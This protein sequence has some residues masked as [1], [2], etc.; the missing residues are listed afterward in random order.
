MS[1]YI[2]LNIRVNIMNTHVK[3]RKVGGSLM[4]SLPRDVVDALG[5][6]PGQTLPVSVEDGRLV[7]EPAKRKL[8]L[9]DRLTMCDFSR[10]KPEWE[11]EWESMPSVGGEVLE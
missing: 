2:T 1:C 4:L 7:I 11:V 9:K 6:A 10:A 5:L 8:T 3:T